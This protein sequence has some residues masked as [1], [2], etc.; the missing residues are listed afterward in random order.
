MH[1]VIGHATFGALVG[2]AIGWVGGWAVTQ[3]YPS[4]EML[5]PA[6]AVAAAAAVA[7]GSGLLFGWLPARRAARLDPVVALAKR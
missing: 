1:R 7:L 5:A 3:L 4:L 2:I 6:W